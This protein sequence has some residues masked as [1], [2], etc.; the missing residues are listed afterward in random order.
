MHSRDLETK[1]SPLLSQL[2]VIH[3]QLP[4][5]ASAS[6]AIE[7]SVQVADKVSQISV[8]VQPKS[9]HLKMGVHGVEHPGFSLGKNDN[10]LTG[11][12]QQQSKATSTF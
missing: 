1:Y 7:P 3:P 11:G 8:Q 10:F 2:T 6:S 4:A 5:V 9:S 12:N